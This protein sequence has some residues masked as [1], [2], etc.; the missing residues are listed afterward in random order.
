MQDQS[1]PKDIRALF[2]QN[3]PEAVNDLLARAA[4]LEQEPDDGN[5]PNR[6]RASLAGDKKPLSK[7]PRTKN[8]KG[9]N[10]SGD[11][12]M[13]AERI[14]ALAAGVYYDGRQYYFDN[15][16]VFVPMNRQSVGA[17]IVDAGAK[18]DEQQR[19]VN[20]VHLNHYV[21]HVGP[22]AGH[23][24]GIYRNGGGSMLVVNSPTII[25]PQ[26]GS[27]DNLKAVIYAVIGDDPEVGNIQVTIFLLWI[28]FAYKALVNG[29]RSP[30]QALVLAGPIRCGKSLLIDILTEVLGG[31]RGN[32]HKYL[33]GRTTFN[34]ELVGSELQVIDDESGSTDIKTRRLV[35]ASYKTMLFSGQVQ[36]EAKYATPMSCA[37][38]WRL[39]IACNDEPESLLVLPP[40]TSDIID[41]VMIFRCH[42]RP[43]PMPLW[44]QDKAQVFATLVAEIPA[45]LA[46]VLEMDV[47]A[48]LRDGRCGVTYF[49][50][51][52]LMAELAEMSPEAEML[53]IID[54]V[55]PILPGKTG[56]FPWEGTAAELRQVLLANKDVE[57][58]T[59]R[60]LFNVAVTGKY[61]G[62]LETTGRVERLRMLNGYQNWRI[63][64]LISA[65]DAFQNSRE[66]RAKAAQPDEE[67]DAWETIVEKADDESVERPD[68]QTSRIA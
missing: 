58:D 61:L 17:H 51:P 50:H 28:K 37:P 23:K 68:G 45:M 62:R 63:K 49:Q 13:S 20:H 64:P 8:S 67:D 57:K 29:V 19:V 25:D 44:A 15:G 34:G 12:A 52:V 2:Q 40:I 6:E 48:D 53:Q 33:T 18:D 7:L 9:A 54:Q 39:V 65:K 56:L 1:E 47:P 38:L 10:Q 24:R 31:R 3:G 26:E 5:E 14:R 16:N 46:E 27:W 60:L 42:K 55:L 66:R 4:Q 59:R 11:E 30:G 22:L 32:P 21:Q 43:F 35:S 36:I 41:K